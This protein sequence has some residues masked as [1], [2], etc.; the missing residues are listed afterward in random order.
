VLFP[1]RRPLAPDPARGG[2][3]VAAARYGADARPE[4]L[5]LTGCDMSMPPPSWI[6]SRSAGL[7]R[8]IAPAAAARV[9]AASFGTE[10]RAEVLL[11]A[12]LAERDLDADGVRFWLSVY[13]SLAR[14]GRRGAGHP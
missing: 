11:R 4:R 6:R 12:F 7:W 9:A 1:Q 14:P 10:A 5:F 13:D 8:R 2:G 3:A